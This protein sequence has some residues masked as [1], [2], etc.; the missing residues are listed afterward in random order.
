METWEKI[1]ADD[2]EEILNLIL[3][4]HINFYYAELDIIDVCAKWV[5][6]RSVP[7][8]KFMLIEHAADEIRHSQHFKDGI[9]ALGLKW[10]E[11]PMEK[12]QLEDRSERFGRLLTS[13]DEI[14][15]LVGL[16]LYAEGVLAM[17]ELVQLHR[18]KPEYFPRFGEILTDEGRHLKYGLIVAK[19]R[20]Q[21]NPEA[22][23]KAQHYCD[24]FLG[25]MEQYLW[26]DIT[27]AIDLGAKVGYLDGDYRMKC[28]RRFEN[29]MSAIGLTVNW[30]AEGPLAAMRGASSLN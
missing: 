9:E 24:E 22:R 29:V 4:L 12:F 21:D 25:H 13:E 11:L 28:A 8:E 20:L 3:M 27:D 15:V 17:E 5:L 10:D 7:D 18:N 26:S 30:P 1:V 2:G 19:R 23:E 6:R 14:E 16:N